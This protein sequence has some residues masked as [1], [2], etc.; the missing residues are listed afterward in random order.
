[1]PTPKVNAVSERHR[2]AAAEFLGEYV[3][4]HWTSHI[5]PLAEII[6]K[7]FFTPDHLA[8]A[9]AIAESMPHHGDPTAKALMERTI[10]SI[11]EAKEGK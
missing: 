5:E 11:L 1:M 9:R 4:I 6:A 8:T 3:S 2:K 10:L 7:H